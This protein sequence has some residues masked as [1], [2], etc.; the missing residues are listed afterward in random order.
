MVLGLVCDLGSHM[1]TQWFRIILGLGKAVTVPLNAWIGLG[2]WL[3][4]NF[5]SETQEPRAEEV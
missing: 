4:V 5:H 3:T 2:T 1:G